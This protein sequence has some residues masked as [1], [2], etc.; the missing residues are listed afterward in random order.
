MKDENIHK[1]I[2]LNS[3]QLQS[4]I[5]TI[6]ELKEEAIPLITF[7][8]KEKKFFFNP[9]AEKILTKIEG[10]IAVVSVAGMYRT[11]KSYLLN[12]MLLNRSS[13]FQVGPSI[14]PCTKGLWIW[15]KPVCGTSAEGEPL[16]ILIIDTE[17]IGATD[18][19]QNHD[20]KIFTLAL[21]LSS[22]FIYNSKNSID[23]N[24]IQNLSFIV[25]IT[26]NI[27]LS[28]N[29]KKNNTN[30]LSI[31]NNNFTANS[32]S[33]SF[34]N[35]F[36]KENENSD[37]KELAS[38]F[39]SFLW[40]IRDFA[41]RLVDPEGK[42]IT[43]KEY[44]EK[45]LEMQTKNLSDAS[46]Q[47]NKIRSLLKDFFRDRNCITLVRPLTE[48][49]NL[50]NLDK[51]DLSQL[52]PEFSE[53][54]N[55]LRKLVLKQ[56]K[57][58]TLNGKYLNGEMFCNL[59]KSYIEAINQGAVPVIENAWGFM[60]KNEC[61]K[62]MKNSVA[63]YEKY[64]TDNFSLFKHKKI[65][66]T[67][68]ELRKIHR[69][70]KEKAVESFKRFAIGN[71]LDEYL[72]KLKIEIR[73]IYENYQ[74][75]NESEA[76]KASINFLQKNYADIE[77]NI[78]QGN[79]K[80]I[81]D[82]NVDIED[83]LEYF[84]KAAPQGPNRETH[85]YSFVLKN[86][87]EAAEAFYK[88]SQS[89]LEISNGNNSE[90]IKR[91]NNELKD[92]KAEFEKE[93]FSKN[94]SIKKF[95]KEKS[96]LVNS[97]K[98][99]K[100]SLVILEK[101]K[102]Q[103][104]KNLTD[105]LES[106]KKDLE[107]QLK[108]L[109][110]KLAFAEESQ[111]EAE[112]NLKNKE[113]EFLKEKSLLEQKLKYSEK[114]IEDLSSKE[115]DQINQLKN[116]KKEREIFSKD[117]KEKFES[118]IKSLN[119]KMEE[120]QDKN[121][122]LET[123]L[124]D[125]EKRSEFDK[126]KYEENLEEMKK[127]VEDYNA[128]INSTEDEF[129][130]K[131]KRIF[132][133][134]QKSKTEYEFKIQ[135]LQ[136]KQEEL[137]RKSKEQ[138]EKFISLKTKNTKEISMLTQELEFTKSSFNEYKTQMETE[139]NNLQAMIAL[140][141]DKNLN[142]IQS[143]EGY[144]KQIN[145]LKTEMY[146]QMKAFE[147]ESEKTKNR[148]N[149]EIEDLHKKC[150][151]SENEKNFCKENLEKLESSSETKIEQLE[152]ANKE[153]SEKLTSAESKL[154]AINEEHKKSFESLDKQA[155]DKIEE[156][157]KST[158]LEIEECNF[159]NEKMISDMQKFFE[160]ERSNIE[161]RLIDEKD[162]YTKKLTEQETYYAEKFKE[163][164]DSKNK[165][166]EEL[167]EELANIEAEQHEYTIRTEQELSLKAQQIEDLERFFNE[168]KEN[169]LNLQQAHK[170]EV[171]KQLEN[172]SAEKKNLNE[173][174]ENLNNSLNRLEKENAKLQVQKEYLEA[175]IENFKA[176]IESLK[177]QFENAKF[178]LIEKAKNFEEKYKLIYDDLLIK[179]GDYSRDLALKKQEV[180]FLEKKLL[181]QQS[182]IDSINAKNEE[183]LKAYKD[184]LEAEYIEKLH[185]LSFDKE[186]LEKKVSKLLFEYKETEDLLTKEKTIVEKEKA[187]LNE[188]LNYANQEKQE[189]I[190]SLEKEREMRL[191]QLQELKDQNKAEN[192]LKLKENEFL[193][194]KL[195][196]IEES[197][198]ELMSNYENDLQLWENKNKHLEE[199]LAKS[200]QD[201]SDS[202]K[203][204]EQIIEL[205]QKQGFTEKEKFETWQNL[206][207]S[208]I[209]SRYM[210]QIKQFKENYQKAYEEVVS[211]KREMEAEI[212][213][214]TEKIQAEQKNKLLDQGELG[215]RLQ[216]ALETEALLK[217][218]ISE[219]SVSKEKQIAEV[220]LALGK[221]REI[222]K[223]KI[224]EQENKL[225]EYES[226]RSNLAVDNLKEKVN[227]DKEKE[228]LVKEIEIFKEKIVSFERTIMK[229]TSDNKD[230]VREND[231]LKRDNRNVRSTNFLP[232]FSRYATN[233]KDSRNPN[234]S[235]DKSQDGMDFMKNLSSHNINLL[236][237]KLAT[238]SEKSEEEN[239]SSL[240]NI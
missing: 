177:A 155:H 82:F 51:M 157:L 232:K 19:D 98:H 63:V 132:E 2:L 76:E 88:Q 202:N 21:L 183:N 77:K 175:D 171:E 6:N 7:N 97:E 55:N 160:A 213:H 11:G 45:S 66:N 127:K 163:T 56:I 207:Q 152:S 18:E 60:C 125:K 96:E 220:L 217:Q 212:K 1:N 148:L 205:L 62:A 44:L 118:Q 116:I 169:M 38:Y 30:N 119:I 203:K 194:N 65:P 231:R 108:D 200:K 9:D 59:I 123:K 186:F 214:L 26:K 74:K 133:D 41:L 16:S 181:E 164:E 165:K 158:R 233:S 109:K 156:L 218:Q 168:Q 195:N 114:Q 23:E 80:N 124:L 58:K 71:Y 72:I 221:E 140:L 188:K 236:K 178:S 40:V 93:I 105:K 146:K 50:Q 25:N 219:I 192:E 81:C 68:T 239:I 129:K 111:Q 138:E 22:Y 83:F 13:G 193:K 153:L 112:R 107:S 46:E 33:S 28:A 10:A 161:F 196:K 230:L 224:I 206:M 176:E 189:L 174:I 204:Y 15:N 182:Y 73:E 67:N 209:E 228:S 149:Q 29:P 36:N 100:E 222:Y 64:V 85:L 35:S 216:T 191:K 211:R 187:V 225:R 69:E 20:S 197:H 27:Q 134:F 79:Y 172:H 229:L 12:R 154:A 166:I 190:S 139:R 223:I 87:L 101:E 120:L 89:E 99:N 53:Q 136:Y 70:A 137:E 130:I 143:Q 122:D 24:A 102:E 17:G 48:E 113:S 151:E 117:S 54:V 201:L 3:S 131:E 31:N 240:S 75:Q 198:N 150:F 84:K 145:E 95:E 32:N 47:K 126:K 167:E 237:N 135:E 103:I 43:S 173:K 144:I 52:R 208:Q 34:L 86:V 37:I 90:M 210:E 141:E 170:L 4:N 8:T 147:D 78:K 128:I 61:A 184:Q 185:S 42:P 92:L 162:K 226:K 121:I 5:N 14:N 49:S 159:K 234:S 106:I 115:K 142:Q 180:E 91:L 199:K 110:S 57:P 94:E 235:F 227:Y 104:N 39:P 179:T 215:K 238:R